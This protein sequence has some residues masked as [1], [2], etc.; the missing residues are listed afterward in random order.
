MLWL[1]MSAWPY[2]QYNKIK[3]KF[4]L[5]TSGQERTD[6]T[7][8]TDLAIEDNISKAWTVCKQTQRPAGALGVY[9]I[10]FE[11]IDIVGIYSISAHMHL[12][13]ETYYFCL[14]GAVYSFPHQHPT[15]PADSEVQALPRITTWLET[16]LNSP[17]HSHMEEL[18]NTHYGTFKFDYMLS[19]YL[20]LWKLWLLFASVNISNP[21]PNSKLH[22]F[23]ELFNHRIVL[24]EF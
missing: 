24:N 1:K 5:T 12:E 6:T 9:F 11:D 8:L 21:I 18:K 23:P 13:H 22:R 16:I 3:M 2:S 4:T 7:W 10:Y 19:T 15:P 17:A 14:F 20:L